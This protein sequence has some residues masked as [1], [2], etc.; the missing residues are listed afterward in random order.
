MMSPWHFCLVD[1][2]NFSILASAKLEVLLP[3]WFSSMYSFFFGRK[4]LCGN[5]IML[6]RLV[7][8][9][10]MTMADSGWSKGRMRRTMLKYDGLFLLRGGGGAG[11]KT[12]IF[13]LKRGVRGDGSGRVWPLRFY[14]FQQKRRTPCAPPPPRTRYWTTYQVKVTF[15]LNTSISFRNRNIQQQLLDLKSQMEVMSFLFTLPVLCC[16]VTV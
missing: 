2:S 5:S 11:V 15:N 6:T 14:V 8:H 4:R 7:T 12:S 9:G 16:K 3:V 13:L 10:T 1:F